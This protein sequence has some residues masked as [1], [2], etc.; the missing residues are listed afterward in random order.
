MCEEWRND[1]LKFKEWA[2]SNGFRENLQIDRI[3]NSK[4]YSPEN[5]RWVTPKENTRN[6]DIT[7]KIKGIPIAELAEIYNIPYQT[8]WRRLRVGWTTH[9]ALNKPVLKYKGSK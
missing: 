7:L 6:R 3:D 5:C 4:G 8:L 1:Y 9:D 2:L